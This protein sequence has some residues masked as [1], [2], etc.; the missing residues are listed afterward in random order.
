MKTATKL[1]T[2]LHT[3]LEPSSTSARLTHHQFAHQLDTERLDDATVDQR[4]Q[5]FGG[6]AADRAR[7]LAD[8]R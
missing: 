6:C 3:L 8:D 2:S 4:T 1:L 7:R 5:H